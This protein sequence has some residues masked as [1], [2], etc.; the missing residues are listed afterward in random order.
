MKTTVE[1]ADALLTEAKDVVAREGTT[2]RSLL[3]AALRAELDRR[4]AAPP[5]YH[6]IDWSVGDPTVVIEFGPEGWT[7]ALDATYEGRGA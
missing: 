3:E 7:T 2:L 4:R 6:L 5:R 1:I